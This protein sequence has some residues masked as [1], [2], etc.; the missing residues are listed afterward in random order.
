MSRHLLYH[1]V[2]PLIFG[3]FF[4][5]LISWYRDPAHF[6]LREYLVSG[7][8]LGTAVSSSPIWALPYG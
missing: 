8:R 2:L 5:I 1:L 4:E 6:E 3:V 7:E